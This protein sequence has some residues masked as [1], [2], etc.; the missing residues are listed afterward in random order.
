MPKF[1]YSIAEA[2]DE[3]GVH[4]DTI[5]RAIRAHEIGHTHIGRRK[6]ITHAWLTKWAFGEAEVIQPSKTGY[7]V[8]EAGLELGVHEDAIYAAIRVGELDHSRIGRR[9]V[10][11]HRQLEDWF[12]ALPTGPRTDSPAAA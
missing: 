2:A 9:I 8:G 11:S 6:V 3:I 12:N 1:A 5:Y 7:N 4:K 10:I